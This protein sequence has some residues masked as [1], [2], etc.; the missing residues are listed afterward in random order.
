MSDIITFT[1]SIVALTMSLFTLWLTFFNRGKVRMTL[2]SMVVFGYDTRGSH[3]GFDPKIMVRSHIFSTG[4]RGQIIEALFAQLHFSTSNEMF[5]VWGVD[6]D[7]KL[8]R[9]GGLWVGKTGVTAWHHFVASTNFKF[10]PGSYTLEVFARVHGSRYPKKLSSTTLL[11]PLETSISRHDGSEQMWFDL[12]PQ[13][14]EFQPR[15]ESRGEIYSSKV[16]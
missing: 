3:N 8:V 7:N 11:I 13:T 5:P 16:T 10:Q 15:L 14:G 12:E 6:A 4:E 2:P 9:G 1:I